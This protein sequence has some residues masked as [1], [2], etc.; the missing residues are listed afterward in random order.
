MTCICGHE[1]CWAC[2]V[3]W[4]GAAHGFY[5][6]PKYK[7]NQDS[8][9]R[10]EEQQRAIRELGKFKWYTALMEANKRDIK[11]VQEKKER[12]EKELQDK[13]RSYREYS[14][15]FE[16]LDTLLLAKEQMLNMSI[17]A[18][19]FQ[20]K[21]I[22]WQCSKCTFNNGFGDRCSMC[23]AERPNEKKH[24]DS[25]KLLFEQQ[26]KMSVDL[27]AK[28]INDLAKPT[29]DEILNDMTKKRTILTRTNACKTF[30]NT[31]V[32]DVESG[33]YDAYILDQPDD[34][35]SGWYCIR[36]EKMNPF[37]TVVCSSPGCDACQVHGEQ[38]CLRCNPKR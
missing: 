6:C 26:Q 11:E 3:K 17:I 30:L 37:T 7:K 16:A 10:D 2:K 33:K 1:F 24:T 25:V 29:I 21:S 13:R 18:F 23:Q 19:Y 8:K 36:C 14:F 15:I 12:W 5:N 27:T 32:A 31:L 20:G 9:A 38:S 4:S 28:L 22:E 34:S 35:V